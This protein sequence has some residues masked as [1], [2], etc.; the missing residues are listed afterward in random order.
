MT[1]MKTLFVSGQHPAKT[2]QAGRMPAYW[3]GLIRLREAAKVRS[4]SGRPQRGMRSIP[5]MDADLNRK[6]SSSQE[7]QY[8]Q[9][10]H[11]D[12][13]A[14]TRRPGRED[15]LPS[16]GGRRLLIRKICPG[17][18]GIRPGAHG[19]ADHGLQPHQRR[20]LHHPLQHLQAQFRSC[21]GRIPALLGP[22]DR[23]AGSGRRHHREFLPV[24]G[25]AAA[26]APR[27]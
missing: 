2:D 1:G 21:G 22:C 13:L 17:L 23:R 14:R 3:P 20:A 10:D 12:P 8:E 24:A 9:A 16:S 25:R 6:R 15:S 4:A 27:L 19:R 7:E 26:H 5:G 18:P 11:R